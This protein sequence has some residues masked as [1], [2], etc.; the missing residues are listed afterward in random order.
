MTQK[1]EL[2]VEKKEPKFKR[3]QQMKNLEKII[4]IENFFAQSNYPEF[5]KRRNE[6]E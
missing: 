5:I 6:I 3:G 1:V 2:L 4:G